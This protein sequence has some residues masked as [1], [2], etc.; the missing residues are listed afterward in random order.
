MANGFGRKSWSQDLIASVLFKTAKGE[1]NTC[2]GTASMAMPM[3]AQNKKI[4]ILES[5]RPRRSTRVWARKRC[6]KES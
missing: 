6:I 3:M 5:T 2:T 4:F 1:K